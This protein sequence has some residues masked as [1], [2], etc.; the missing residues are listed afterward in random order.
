MD[1]TTHRCKKLR[2]ALNQGS[3]EIT[4]HLNKNKSLDEYVD[5]VMKKLGIQ[6]QME[7]P[8]L[9]EQ[10]IQLGQEIE[11]IIYTYAYK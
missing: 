6:Y 4:C 5:T 10:N 2:D 8:N 1:E 3:I 11:I 7:K 9:I